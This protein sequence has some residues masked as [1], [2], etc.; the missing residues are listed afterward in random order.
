MVQSVQMV[1]TPARSIQVLVNVRKAAAP[2]V[3]AVVALEVEVAAAVVVSN[4][5]SW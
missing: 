5:N 2:E 4:K 3:A 1:K